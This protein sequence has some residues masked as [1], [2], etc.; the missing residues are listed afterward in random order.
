MM[1]SKQENSIDLERRKRCVGPDETRTQ[2]RACKTTSRKLLN[3]QY[4][5][6][7]K[8]CASRN[9]YEKCAPRKGIGCNGKA[10][11][12]CISSDR[13]DNAAG[14]ECEDDHR[15][16]SSLAS[17][18]FQVASTCFILVSTV[19]RHR[20]IAL[21][22]LLDQS[23]FLNSLSNDCTLMVP[24]RLGSTESCALELALS[25][26]AKCVRPRG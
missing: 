11:R 22:R 13:P 5:K 26:P 16:R 10:Q 3:Q 2:E 23:A 12:Y 7:A 25:V 8:Y 6:E 9:I 15:L 18:A 17:S 20:H 4:E 24:P 21:A 1:C 14:T 19:A